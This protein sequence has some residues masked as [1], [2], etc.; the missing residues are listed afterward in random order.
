MSSTED[1][2]RLTGSMQMYSLSTKSKAKLSF[3]DMDNAFLA[4]L[5]KSTLFLPAL[6][7]LISFLLFALLCPQAL[8]NGDAALYAQQIRDL[9][10][11]HRTVHLG[12]YLIGIPFIH[13]L[14]LPADY[15]LNLI[16][17]FYGALCVSALFLITVLITKSIQASFIA[18]LLL[19]TNHLF[20]SNA[21]CAEVYVPQLFFFLLLIALLLVNKPI[22]AGF[23]C[24]ISCLITPSAIFGLATLIP[25]RRNRQLLFRFMITAL[26]AILFMVSSNFSDYIMGGRGLLKASHASLSIGAAFL[27]EYREF[28]CGILWY[29]PFL[30]AGVVETIRCRKYH[31][32]GMSIFIIWLLTFIAGERFGDVPVQLP[33]YALICMIGGL[34]FNAVLKLFYEK[35]RIITAG[36]YFFLI[37]AVTLSGLITRDRLRESIAEHQEYRDT[38]FALRHAAQPG[39][40]ALG[41]WTQGVLLEHYLY[42]KSYAGVWI[43]TEWL[44]GTWGAAQRDRC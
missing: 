33:C 26:A 5:I 39:F 8:S 34:G 31:V 28:F 43:N 44:T 3:F 16:N 19:I 23:S 40:I 14:P 7:F 41:P 12:Y 20:A 13:L 21:V 27:K 9:D 25:F 35:S 1:P 22:T 6:L 4:A 24:A 29:L 11:A 38:V 42:G 37:L 30:L 32:W 10:F 36:V 2:N 17:C 18:C 15:A